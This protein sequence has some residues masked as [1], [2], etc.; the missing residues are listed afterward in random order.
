MAV[1]PE[2]QRRRL[3]GL[4]LLQS[5]A[6]APAEALQTCLSALQKEWRKHDHLAALWQDWP[7]VAGAQLAPHCRPLSLQRGV[8]TVGASHPQWRQ[9]LLYNKPQLISALHQAGHAVRDLRIQQH[10]PLQSSHQCEM[11][12]LQRSSLYRLDFLRYLEKQRQLLN[13]Q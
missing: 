2:S 10:H 6:P 1:A 5:A 8:L 4:E 12:Y 3:P 11:A 7:R 9:A 13:L